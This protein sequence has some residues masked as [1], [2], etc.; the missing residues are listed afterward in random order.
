MGYFSELDYMQ[1]EEAEWSSPTKVQQLVDRI[2]CLNESL[3]DLE[4]QC[5]RDMLNPEYDNK[6]YSECLTGTWADVDTIQGVL[7]NLRKTKELLRI[8]EVE[9]QRELKE[10][11]ECMDLRSAVWE[12]GATPD[13]QI[14]LLNVFFPAADPSVAA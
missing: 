10:Q 6:F 1:R 12:T 3:V 13:Y 9:E 11:Q 2:D 14:V 8:A 7:H 5:P 4:N